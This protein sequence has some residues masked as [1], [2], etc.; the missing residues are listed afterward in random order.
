MALCHYLSLC[1]SFIAS[2]IYWA[3]SPWKLHQ[4][5]GQLHKHFPDKDGQLFTDEA[6]VLLAAATVC[7]RMHVHHCAC[8]WETGREEKKGWWRE[9]VMYDHFWFGH[10]QV[11]LQGS[12]CRMPLVLTPTL[13][14][15]MCLGTT[16]NRGGEKRSLSLLKHHHF[17]V[18]YIFLS[19]TLPCPPRPFCSILL[20]LLIFQ[21]NCYRHH[22]NRWTG[23]P[24]HQH[25]ARRYCHW[26][27]QIYFKS[28][29]HLLL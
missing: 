16:K 27:C 29:F 28:P 8:L 26:N 25:R 23:L 20:R 6:K 3:S 11:S 19:C 9:P 1:Y 13:D 24:K 5:Y 17:L 2:L 14:S 18:F 10:L 22:C 21:L 4:D 7:V 12:I 15:T